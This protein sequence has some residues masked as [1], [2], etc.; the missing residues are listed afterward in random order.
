MPLGF[1]IMTLGKLGASV[2]PSYCS[3]LANLALESL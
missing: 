2:L 3:N 1:L